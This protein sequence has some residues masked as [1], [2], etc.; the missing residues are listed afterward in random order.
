MAIKLYHNITG[1]TGVDVELI[2][3]GSDIN[4]IKSIVLSNVRASNDATVSLFIQSPTLNKS[5]HII[6]T[7]NLP[8]NTSLV[9][10]SGDIPRFNNSANGYG[11][12][13]T[14]GGSDEVDVLLNI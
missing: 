10:E 5:Y 7:V 14:V 9:L 12:N 8:F 4:A 1:S 6:K 3:P 2:A 13:I 11:L